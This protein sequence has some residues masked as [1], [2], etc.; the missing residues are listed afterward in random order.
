MSCSLKSYLVLFEIAM[1]IVNSVMLNKITA[2]SKYLLLGLLGWA[3]GVMVTGFMVTG[4]QSQSVR[5]NYLHFNFDCCTGSKIHPS[6][7]LKDFS[8]KHSHGRFDLLLE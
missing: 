8:S 1:C 3:A 7:S 6:F 4:G 2:V 5:E